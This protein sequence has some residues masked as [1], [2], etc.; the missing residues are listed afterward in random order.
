MSRRSCPAFWVACCAVGVTL[1]ACAPASP[2]PAPPSHSPTATISQTPV[3]DYTKPGKAVA[4]IDELLDAAGTD[5]VLMVSV[6]RLDVTVSVLR[7][8]K[9]ETWSFRQGKATQVETDLA[10]VDQATFDIDD[11]NLDDLGVLFRA[12]VAVSGSDS[13]QELQIVDA[14]GGEIRMSVSTNP[15]SRPVFFNRDGTLMQTLDLTSGWG[16]AAAF[17]EVA[18]AQ[19]TALEVGFGNQ[20]VYFEHRSDSGKNITRR[21]RGSWLPLTVATRPTSDVLESFVVPQDLPERVWRVL[22]AKHR[23][24]EFRLN[25]QWSCRIRDAGKGV[26]LSFTI[27]TQSFTTDIDGTD[28]SP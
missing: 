13:G 11:W 4:A 19:V 8:K 28:V 6:K 15:E 9:A 25:D 10:Y 27:G 14:L 17:D 1:T 22:D 7:D 20:N 18:D 26:R 2:I 23:S 16:L 12:A 21:S 5:D 3:P 24:G